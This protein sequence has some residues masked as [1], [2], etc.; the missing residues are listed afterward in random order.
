MTGLY[1]SERGGPGEEGKVSTIGLL[2]G[3]LGKSHY[4]IS[5]TMKGPYG[6]V[7]LDQHINQA[8]KDGITRPPWITVAGSQFLFS[9]LIN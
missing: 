1:D 6:I 2:P 5:V 7:W 4:I 3:L 9:N 8:S